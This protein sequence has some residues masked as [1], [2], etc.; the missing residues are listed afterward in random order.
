MLE[1]SAEIKEKLQEMAHEASRPFCY[2][3]YVTVEADENGQ[4][5]CRS[6]GGG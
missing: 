2:S 3:V 4:Y 1:A 5:L 6:Q